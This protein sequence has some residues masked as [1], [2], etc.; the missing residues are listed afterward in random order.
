VLAALVALGLL[1]VTGVVGVPW[2]IRGDLIAN[3]A[4]TCEI[5][6]AFVRE[7]PGAIDDGP[8]EVGRCLEEV[9]SGL[10]PSIRQRL[11]DAMAQHQS[12]LRRPSEP[13][14]GALLDI[15]I[16]NGTFAAVE[17]CAG[18][19]TSHWR[20]GH[21]LAMRG[22]LERFTREAHLERDG[23][24]R[25]RRLVVALELWVDAYAML[26]LSI[27]GPILWA[28]EI[29]LSAGDMS[30]E[31]ATEA[32]ERM[33]ALAASL[34]DIETAT[35]LFYCSVYGEVRELELFDAFE[36]NEQFGASL[37]MAAETDPAT[38]GHEPSARRLHRAIPSG[39]PHDQFAEPGSAYVAGTLILAARHLDP[40]PNDFL[41]QR[42]ESADLDDG[43]MSHRPCWRL[44]LPSALDDRELELCSRDGRASVASR[45][46]ARLYR[47]LRRTALAGGAIPQRIDDRSAESA[48]ESASASESTSVVPAEPPCT[49][50][51]RPPGALE[52][53]RTVG[54]EAPATSRVALTL[55]QPET[56]PPTRPGER[57][58][59]GRGWR[60]LRARWRLGRIPNL[61]DPSSLICDGPVREA[62]LWIDGPA[63]DPKPTPLELGEVSEPGAERR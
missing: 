21:G 13:L 56:P 38:W 43:P 27:T 52:A 24:Q 47:A 23:D 35:A 51:P 40:E 5:A 30:P 55:L 16:G 25:L 9:L 44:V 8:E 32:A 36:A 49:E 18:A 34:P 63:G 29:G 15:P 10:D 50:E 59:P 45:E 11:E 2:V 46:L 58:D 12:S 42:I 61:M 62:R 31:T 7:R 1:V 20:G 6:E 41:G 53:W 48:S 33:R 3:Q 4:R 54:Y 37:A 28:R 57:A 60:L 14:H 39:V 19:R 26:D 17:R 22:L